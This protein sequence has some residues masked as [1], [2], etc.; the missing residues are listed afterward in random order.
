MIAD[1]LTLLGT[2]GGLLFLALVIGAALLSVFCLL[3][4]YV[5][6]RVG[7]RINQ[8]EAMNGRGPR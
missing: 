7:R 6:A 1:T 3:V 4:G 8:I 2:I 5:G